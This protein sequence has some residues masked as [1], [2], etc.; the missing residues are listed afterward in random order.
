MKEDPN[1]Y[2]YIFAYANALIAAGKT[3]LA[4]PHLKKCIE[5]NPK[6]AALYYLSLANVYHKMLS[7]E[8]E[9]NCL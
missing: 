1:N 9:I 4:I 5:L 2:L 3:R 8:Q 7:T 6:K